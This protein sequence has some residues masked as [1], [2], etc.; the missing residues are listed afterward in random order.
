MHQCCP[1][2]R[3]WRRPRPGRSEGLVDLAQDTTPLRHSSPSRLAR[4]RRRS[5]NQLSPSVLVVLHP[6]TSGISKRVSR[7]I[8]QSV[9]PFNNERFVQVTAERDYHPEWREAEDRPDLPEDLPGTE[10]PSLVGLMRMTREEWDVWTR[11]S[12]IR[13]AGYA[14]LKRNVAVAIGNWLASV[15]KPPEE[16]VAALR[17][18]LEDEE[19]L[20]REH[21]AW[22]L[23]RSPVS[24]PRRS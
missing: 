1:S 21:A 7:R 10:S 17:D 20:V 4:E 11:G 19:P 13:R 18:A 3:G 2:P 6:V 9:C 23:Q 12:A 16:A 14:G 8:S 22:A 5:A 15:D 24:S